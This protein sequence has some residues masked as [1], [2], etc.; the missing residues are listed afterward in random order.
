MGTVQ[1]GKGFD[2]VMRWFFRR[3][4]TEV[5]RNSVIKELLLQLHICR[6]GAESRDQFTSNEN[7]TLCVDGGGHRMFTSNQRQKKYDYT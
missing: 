3:I 1:L 2:F 5:H 6:R 7:G 4:Q